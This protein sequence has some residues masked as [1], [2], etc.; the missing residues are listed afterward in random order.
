ME[1]IPAVD[2]MRG[3]VVRLVKGDPKL[4]KSYNN[5]GDPLSIAQ[6]WEREGAQII[7][8]VDL[9]SALG[10]RNNM[11]I[12]M[13]IVH[14]IR[15]PVQVGGGIRD[16]KKARSLLTSGVM[17]VILGSIAFEEPTVIEY[18]LGEFPGKRIVVALDCLEGKVMIRGWKRSSQV[19]LED[20]LARFREMGVS[21]FLLTSVTRDGTLSGPDIVTL[22]KLGNMTQHVIAAG[23][24]RSLDDI[25]SLK[26]LGL[27]GVVVGKA[28]YENF[29]NLREALAVS[30]QKSVDL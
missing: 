27:Y 12:I 16:I 10:L 20:A 3:Q 14:K 22:S 4:L 28:L 18:L 19:S 2:I 23:G 6:K 1:L 7:H 13:D 24:I 8:V 11:S 30:Q 26:C 21:L 15:I 29:F 25:V 5:L 9:D 17:R